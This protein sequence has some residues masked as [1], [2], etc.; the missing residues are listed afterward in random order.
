MAKNYVVAAL[1]DAM[2]GRAVGVA[3]TQAYGC[4]VKYSD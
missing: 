1:D 3:H 4:S 2:A